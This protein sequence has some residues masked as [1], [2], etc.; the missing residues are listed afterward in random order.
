MVRSGTLM[1]TSGEDLLVGS[2]WGRTCGEK[3]HE[4]REAARIAES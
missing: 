3:G 2:T 4:A 1:L